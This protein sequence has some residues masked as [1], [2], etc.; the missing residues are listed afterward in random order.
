MMSVKR[1]PDVSLQVKHHVQRKHG[2]CIFSA[3]PLDPVLINIFCWF[4][5]TGGQSVNISLLWQ[6]S[7]CIVLHHFPVLFVIWKTN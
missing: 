2:D 7:D 3:W 6:P 5:N 1:R 4:V